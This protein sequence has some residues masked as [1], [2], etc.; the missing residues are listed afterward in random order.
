MEELAG[1]D[2]TDLA[3]RSWEQWPSALC[4][5]PYIHQIEGFAPGTPPRRRAVRLA[6]LWKT[7]VLARAFSIT[8]AQG[9]VPCSW[10]LKLGERDDGERLGGGGGVV[11]GRVG[12]VGGGWGF[13]GGGGPGPANGEL[14]FG[15][16]RCALR[17]T[18]T[19]ILGFF[20]RAR[21]TASWRPAD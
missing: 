10:Q 16:S 4:S 14:E 7:L 19:S 8:V 3:W 1:H 11:V 21:K 18:L 9:T 20:Y 2:G 6:E 17:S 5:S 12:G 15:A 13:W